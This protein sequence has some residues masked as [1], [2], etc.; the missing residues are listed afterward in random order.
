MVISP[1]LKLRARI[2]PFVT[3]PLTK[4]CNFRCQY[5]GY[6]GELSASM[7]HSQ[8]FSVIAERVVTAHRLGVRKFRFTGG[9]PF[10]HPRLGDLVGLLGELGVYLLINTN[11]SLVAKHMDMVRGTGDNVRFA[12]SLDTMDPVKF[13]ELSGT[14]GNYPKV[15]EGIEAICSAA[16]LL[17]LN[18]VVTRLN[19]DEVPDIIDYCSELGCA[20]KL[21][22]VVSVPLPY[23]DRTAL[24]VPLTDT[25][26]FLAAH[27]TVVEEHQYARSFGTPCSIF[28]YKGVR[29]TAK[30]TWNG[31]HYDVEGICADCPY[32]P[33]HEGLYDVF[34]LPDG[35]VVGCRWS[36]TSV[37]DPDASFEQQL[38]EMAR[39]FQRADYVPR[40]Q[41]AAMRPRPAFVTDS[42]RRAGE[43]VP[44]SC[45]IGEPSDA[46]P[47]SQSWR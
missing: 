24:H 14:R 29:I 7:V 13:D 36:E 34:S 46:C 44:G 12:V 47:P 43:Q 31:S 27:A 32:Y 25:E 28:V 23:G 10:T 37:G 1:E 26:R 45:R 20:L 33:C 22:D 19:V 2:M 40:E 4:T 39:I 35:R 21:L 41:N 16:R 17:R 18:M 15:R 6:G 5:C 38:E 11:G 30:S 9:E 42:L 3:F 8:D